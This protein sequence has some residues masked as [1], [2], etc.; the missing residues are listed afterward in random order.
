MTTS[1]FNTPKVSV[2]G[3]CDLRIDIIFYVFFCC[4]NVSSILVK[5]NL[6]ILAIN[7][8]CFFE[9]RLELSF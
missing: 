1:G 6:I 3:S 7:D 4:F 5:Y 9:S 2:V 8:I